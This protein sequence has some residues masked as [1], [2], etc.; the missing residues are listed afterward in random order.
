MWRSIVLSLPPQLVFPGSSLACKY[1]TRMK[2]AGSC[3]LFSLQY[4]SHTVTTVKRL[5]AQALGGTVSLNQGRP[6]P[7]LLQ[8]RNPY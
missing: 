1:K 6:V 4:Y 5:I 3:T 8:P 7:S 2:G